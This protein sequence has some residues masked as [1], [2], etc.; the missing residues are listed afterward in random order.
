LEKLRVEAK[1][2][3]N[4]IN[5]IKK[6]ISDKEKEIKELRQANAKLIELNL[7]KERKPASL[8]SQRNAITK[9]DLEILEL[10]LVEKSLNKKLTDTDALIR[11]EQLQSRISQ[12]LETSKSQLVLVENVRRNAKALETSVTELEASS[13][14]NHV[15]YRIL[16]LLWDFP[17]AKNEMSLADILTKWSPANTAINDN[18]DD[19]VIRLDHLRVDSGN[20][21]NQLSALREN[22]RTF[23]RVEPLKK[24]NPP[25]VSDNFVRMQAAGREAEK[26]RQQPAKRYINH[27]MVANVG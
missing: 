16:N 12:L 13:S 6:E 15:L 20:F 1:Q 4:K 8:T 27:N 11:K 3:T 24:R 14:K 26:I 21:W 2:L 9:I 25:L 23:H 17:D 10:K 22:K 7:G 19:L 5:L 18:F